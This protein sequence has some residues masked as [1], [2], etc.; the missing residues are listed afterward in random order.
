MRPKEKSLKRK[1]G[2]NPKSHYHANVILYSNE[3]ACE[4]ASRCHVNVIL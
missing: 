1:V 3:P 2:E 4:V